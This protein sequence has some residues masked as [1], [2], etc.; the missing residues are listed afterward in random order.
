MK[1]LLLVLLITNFFSCINNKEIKDKQTP[2]YKDIQKQEGLIHQNMLSAIELSITVISDNKRIQR[3][4]KRKPAPLKKG[5]QMFY[6]NKYMTRFSLRDKNHDLYVIDPIDINERGELPVQYV[7]KVNQKVK[8]IT[9]DFYSNNIYIFTKIYQPNETITEF[10]PSSLLESGISYKIKSY[11]YN[12]YGEEKTYNIDIH[13]KKSKMIIHNGKKQNTYQFNKGITLKEA[14]KDIDI[15]AKIDSHSRLLSFQSKENH[16]PQRISSSLNKNDGYWIFF[17]THSQNLDQIL[18]SNV[19][20]LFFISLESL[21]KHAPKQIDSFTTN[22]SE[23]KMNLSNL[24]H[25]FIKIEGK[26][27]QRAIAKQSFESREDSNYGQNGSFRCRYTRNELTEKSTFNLAEDHFDRY[28]TFTINGQ[29]L[30]YKNVV[31][32][33]K[34]LNQQRTKKADLSVKLKRT[35]FLTTG[36]ISSNCSIFAVNPRPVLKYQLA[37]LHIELHHVL[38]FD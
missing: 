34:N 22:K 26:I 1:T 13:S 27:T 11:S 33:L 35:S 30:D 10:L 25:A 36:I 16:S 19:I 32:H 20:Y 24:H 3:I 37:N 12:Q 7:L 18:D 21:Y 28:L 8:D 14:L 31:Y 2:K 29:I 23:V 4:F 38:L 5:I 15:N 6:N 17:N 9:L